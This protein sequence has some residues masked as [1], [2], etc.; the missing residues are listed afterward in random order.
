MLYCHEVTSKA[1]WKLSLFPFTAA[2]RI[3]VEFTQNMVQ[4]I[5]QTA[6]GI[7]KL[8]V[9][10]GSHSVSRKRVFW[11]FYFCLKVSKP[12]GVHFLQGE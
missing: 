5:S 1:L 7:D 11:L 3:Q 9:P 2:Y 10:C 8:V 12:E 4:E 6:N